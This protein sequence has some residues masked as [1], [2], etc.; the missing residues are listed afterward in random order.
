MNKSRTMIAKPAVLAVGPGIFAYVAQTQ[1]FNTSRT[2]VQS[3]CT[4]IC[5]GGFGFGGPV[6]AYQHANDNDLA[7]SCLQ[8]APPA[9][10]NMGSPK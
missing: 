4:M 3:A 5:G 10:P 9:N 6:G 7:A 8:S 2:R 1:T